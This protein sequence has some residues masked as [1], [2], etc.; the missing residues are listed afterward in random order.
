MRLILRIDRFLLLLFT[1]VIFATLFPYEEIHNAFFGYLTKTA[2]ALLFF[3]HGSKLSRAAILMGVGHWKLHLM[4]FS[5]TFV[6]FPL[7]G[8]A[9]NVLVPYF[10][11]PSLYL[12]FLYLCALPATV[13][14]AISYTSIAGGNVA[15]AICSASASSLLGIFLSPL[16]IGW[17][18]RGEGSIDILPSISAIL[19]Q[20]MLPFL[21]GHLSRPMLSKWIEHHQ[22]WLNIFDRATILLVV[23]IAFNEAVLEGIWQKVNIVSLLTI[24]L[25][26]SV[27]LA[28][29]LFINTMIPRWL[30]FN[31]ADE[32][33]IVFCGSKKSL[34]NGISMANVL[35]PAAT[36]GMMV[37]PL[38]IFHQI[39]L[40]VCA[41][42]AK[43][44]AMRSKKKA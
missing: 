40:T 25:I 21:L 33:T 36:V 8:I 17:L 44:Y 18:M 10:L 41:V 34:V 28:L 12:G 11:V 24:I 14:T 37:L 42:L 22:N 13:Q 15:A 35:F 4:V 39:Q 19:L 31:L 2:I 26:S 38:M 32:I 29:V 27:L 23:Y 3:A 20:L 5:S 7:L 43:K 6:L 16:L 30:G 1:I 9:L